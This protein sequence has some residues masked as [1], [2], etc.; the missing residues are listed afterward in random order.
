MDNISKNS[1]FKSSEVVN[2]K[3]TAPRG[4]M[5]S[6][7]LCS[8]D[9]LAM[10]LGKKLRAVRSS[11]GLRQEDLATQSG[12]SLQAIKNLENGGRVELLTF[13]RAVKALGLSE[14]LLESC[15]PN[16][17]SIDEIERL[18]ASVVKGARVRVKF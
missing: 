6:A 3:S 14:K 10:D 16:P 11:L 7:M 8:P 13:I 4:E 17:Q 5:I 2:K 15:E 9:E 1:N 18:E 12:A